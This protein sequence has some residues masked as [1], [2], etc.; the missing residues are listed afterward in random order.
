MRS[1][2]GSFGKEFYMFWTHLLSIIKSLNTIFTAIGICYASYVACLLARSGW[3]SIM[4]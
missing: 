3:S 2:A 4:T 1:F